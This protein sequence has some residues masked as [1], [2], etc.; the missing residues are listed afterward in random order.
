VVKCA[1]A[2]RR[3]GLV[4]VRP[5]LNRWPNFPDLLPKDYEEDF[6]SLRKAESIG[7]PLGTADFVT[8]LERRFGRPIARRTVSVTDRKWQR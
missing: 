6:T 8:G 2:P 4:S 1:G 5:V 7:C 3:R